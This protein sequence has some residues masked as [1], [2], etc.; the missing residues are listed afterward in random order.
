MSTSLYTF[1]F[2]SIMLLIFSQGTAKKQREEKHLRSTPPKNENH[3]FHQLCRHEH[4]KYRKL[5]HVNILR[6]NSTLYIKA[7]GWASYLSKL[8]ITTDVPHEYTPGIGE[9]IYWMTNAQ[10]PYTQYAEK[11]VQYWYAEN[12]YYNYDTGRFS[13]NTAHFTQMVW[14]STTQVGCGYNVSRTLTL[15]VVCKCFPQGNIA[16]QYQSNVLRPSQ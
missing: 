15:F 3:R 4:N 6:T 11:A 16:G 2:L 1:I 10:K 14:K 8:D 7:R 13:P 12:K 5:H 9:N